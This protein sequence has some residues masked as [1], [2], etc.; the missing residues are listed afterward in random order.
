MIYYMIF[1]NQLRAKTLSLL[2]TTLQD[3]KLVFLSKEVIVYQL[4][5]H[6]TNFMKIK[7]I[8]LETDNKEKMTTVHFDK[9][10]SVG[11]IPHKCSNL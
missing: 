7:Q 11:K 6:F 10:Y 1:A 3:L 8:T 2:C 4:I 5:P 9:C